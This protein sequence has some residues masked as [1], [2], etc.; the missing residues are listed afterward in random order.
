M[1][2]KGKHAR[3]KVRLRLVVALL[4]YKWNIYWHLKIAEH[5]V[6]TNG[7]RNIAPRAPKEEAFAPASP[8]KLSSSNVLRS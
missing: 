2:T 3:G 1:A 6:S 8:G 5:L 4:F 7:P